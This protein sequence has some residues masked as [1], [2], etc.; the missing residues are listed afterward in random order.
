MSAIVIHTN[1]KADLKILSELSLKLGSDVLSIS[2]E[3]YEDLALGKLMDKVK[4]GKDASR[5]SV[6]KKLKT[7]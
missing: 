2:E 7:K 3:Q 6:M 1:S 5:E 4:T